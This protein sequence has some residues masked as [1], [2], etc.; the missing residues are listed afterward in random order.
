MFANI[1]CMYWQEI[2]T[3]VEEN[4][5]ISGTD[6]DQKH[7]IGTAEYKDKNTDDILAKKYKY[8]KVGG[9]ILTMYQLKSRAGAALLAWSRSG[10]WLCI[11]PPAF[12]I[13]TLMHYHGSNKIKIVLL[14]C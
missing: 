11:V 14:S 2:N 12:Y 5:N 8:K 9:Q 7:T 13:G 4:R 6:E 1:Q 10:G 3:K